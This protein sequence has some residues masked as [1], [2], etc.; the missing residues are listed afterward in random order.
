MVNLSTLDLNLLVMLDAL[1]REAHVGRA[2]ARVGLS[3]PAAS[4]ALRRLRDLFEDPLLVQTGRRMV[5]SPRAETLRR[6][7]TQILEGVNGLFAPTAFHPPTSRRTFRLMMPDLVSDQIVP[8]LVELLSV[9]APGVHV[10]IV[11]WRGSETLTDDHLASLDLVVSTWIGRFNS[12]EHQLLYVDRDVLAVRQEHPASRR[13]GR[14][15]GF[16]AAQHVAVVGAGEREDPIDTWL[17]GLG[18]ARKVMLTV[19]SY[20]LALRIAGR[21]DL[22]AFVPGRLVAGVGQGLGLRAIR[23]PFE[24]DTDQLHLFF[25]HRAQTDEASIWLRN[26]VAE[27]GREF[28]E[29]KVS[30]RSSRGTPRHASVIHQNAA[31]PDRHPRA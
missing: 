25:P 13:L 22:V 8:P 21:T 30:S 5:L 28:S 26:T 7:L 11:P 10:E 15:E 27:I 2:A 1:L 16:L 29:T 6:P 23:P 4:H 9:A 17:R 24:T 20:L 14:L 12:F 19:P 31:L 3:Q 18:Q